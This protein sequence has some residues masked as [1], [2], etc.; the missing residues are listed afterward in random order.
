M[1]FDHLMSAEKRMDAP[2]SLDCGKA[3][4]A[5][6]DPNEWQAARSAHPSAAAR[7]LEVNPQSSCNLH[8]VLA[9][10]AAEARQAEWVLPQNLSEPRRHESSPFRVRPE[11][12]VRTPS[13][14]G[15]AA[16]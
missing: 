9:G 4:R 12:G 11:Q 15:A 16:L 5:T 8:Q 6:H 2:S 13:S 14:S 10:S 7:R 3:R 1:L